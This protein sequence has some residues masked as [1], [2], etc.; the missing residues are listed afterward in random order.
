MENI[1][2]TKV[3]KFFLGEQEV[4]TYKEVAQ[5]YGL[6]L[7]NALALMHHDK[8]AE[9]RPTPLIVGKQSKRYFV[10]SEVDKWI[11]PLVEASNERISRGI[12]RPRKNV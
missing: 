7:T 11:A 4:V 2:I 10:K 12:G 6:M 5:S 8:F 3:T 1:R 9:G